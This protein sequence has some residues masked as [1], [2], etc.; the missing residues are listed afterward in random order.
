M[1]SENEHGCTAKVRIASDGLTFQGFLEFFRAGSLDCY[2]KT[3]AFT[4]KEQA[5]NATVKLVHQYNASQ[6]RNALMLPCFD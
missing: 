3:E 6:G 4:A 1:L 2:Y 5:Q